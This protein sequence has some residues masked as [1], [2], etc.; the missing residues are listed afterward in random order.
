MS[1][2]SSI[3]I[4]IQGNNY[5]LKCPNDQIDKLKSAAEMVHKKMGEAKTKTPSNEKAAILTALNIAHD[6][7]EVKNDVD[8]NETSLPNIAN[9][10]ISSI[11]NG[12]HHRLESCMTKSKK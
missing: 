12:I 6:L 11:I 3:K 7:L 5:D 1:E 10:Q 2:T 4:S 9:D 8:D